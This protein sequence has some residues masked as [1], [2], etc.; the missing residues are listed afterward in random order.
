[1]LESETVRER[2]REIPIQTEKVKEIPIQTEKV[3][4]NHMPLQNS[5]SMHLLNPLAILAVLQGKE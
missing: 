5:S 3:R 2:E 1:V 4:V